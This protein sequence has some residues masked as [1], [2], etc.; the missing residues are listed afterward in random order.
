MHLDLLLWV[1]LA[2]ST[3]QKLILCISLMSLLLLLYASLS[4]STICG[5]DCQL[6]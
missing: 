6:C 2:S 1:K 5:H 3:V 4:S